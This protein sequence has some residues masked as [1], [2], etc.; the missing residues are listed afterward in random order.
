M[1]RLGFQDLIWPQFGEEAVS[2][3]RKCLKFLCKTM[4]FYSTSVLTIAPTNSWERV[5][6]LR[7]HGNNFNE[8]GTVSKGRGVLIT[9]MQMDIADYKWASQVG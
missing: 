7:P 5:A 2:S 3:F 1:P 6:K 9:S 8:K 4:P